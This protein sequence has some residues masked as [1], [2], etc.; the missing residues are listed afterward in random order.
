[1]IR[2]VCRE[3]SFDRADRSLTHRR[4]P[5]AG[6]ID[7]GA[8]L[9]R[10]LR[11]GIHDSLRRELDQCNPHRVHPST[12]TSLEKMAS[13]DLHQFRSDEKA[14]IGS[15]SVTVDEQMQSNRKPL[16]DPWWTFDEFEEVLNIRSK[17]RCGT[18][19]GRYLIDVGILLLEL[20]DPRSLE[21]F[22]V[23]FTLIYRQD[24]PAEVLLVVLHGEAVIEIVHRTE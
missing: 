18:R 20:L 23:L 14:L 4:S 10:P 21:D 13:N 2:I 12:L 9:L 5:A 7:E 24:E 3:G 8:Y 16:I 22:V 6:T 11:H 15:E 1:M 17:V 19:A